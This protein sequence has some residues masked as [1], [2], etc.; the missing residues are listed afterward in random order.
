VSLMRCPGSV[1]HGSTFESKERIRS[2]EWV[3]SKGSSARATV[4]KNGGVCGRSQKSGPRTTARS[5]GPYGSQHTAKTSGRRTR[6][7]SGLDS[8]RA[9]EMRTTGVETSGHRASPKKIPA[10]LEAWGRRG[11]FRVQRESEEQRKWIS[12]M[13]GYKRAPKLSDRAYVERCSCVA[14]LQPMSCE[15][16]GEKG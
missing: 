6:D 10:F 3:D 7:V 11:M 15:G 2:G 1:Y 13:V 12:M 9:L 4:G 8:N 14:E 16:L 5:I